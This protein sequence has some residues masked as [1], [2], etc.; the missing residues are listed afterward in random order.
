M[1]ERDRRIHQQGTG[2]D[3]NSSAPVVVQQKGEAPLQIAARVF[4]W[5][6]NPGS[7]R[8]VVTESAKRVLGYVERVVRK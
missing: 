3:S 6:Q 7:S 5:Y 1:A 8:G 4:G 2:V